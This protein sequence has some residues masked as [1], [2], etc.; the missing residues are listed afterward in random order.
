M[1]PAPRLRCAACPTSQLSTTL[2]ISRRRQVL[3]NTLRRY[4]AA[5]QT[6]TVAAATSDSSRPDG[7]AGVGGRG[8]VAGSSPSGG[9]HDIGFA[10]GVAEVD[11]ELLG[12]STLRGRTDSAEGLER[13]DRHGPQPAR[14][15]PSAQALLAA[16]SE[17]VYVV[18]RQRR[19]TYWNPAA[20][21]LTGY[22]ADQVVGRCCRDGI[23]N[24]VDHE[25]TS[26]C[27]SRC[28]LLATIGDGQPHDMLA[29]L[30]HRDGHRVPVAAR[31]GTGR[32][33]REHHRSR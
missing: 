4:E 22:P 9:E 31:C 3:R 28:P 16:M 33:R 11:E 8:R 20:E 17:A 23:L 14:Y 13:G 29:F 32:P 5:D 25:G 10:E 26:L 1:P 30:H 24:H 15:V 19:V 21:R 18:D 12:L 27:K 6:I 2:V 7:H